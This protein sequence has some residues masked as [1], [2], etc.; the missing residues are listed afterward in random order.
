[1]LIG[2]GQYEEALVSLAKCRGKSIDITQVQLLKAEAY[3]NLNNT[4]RV[5]FWV[6]K[7]Q[8]RTEEGSEPYCAANALLES[9]Q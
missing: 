3:L 9:I 4:S 8:K 7:V 6:N 5:R 1:M 2:V